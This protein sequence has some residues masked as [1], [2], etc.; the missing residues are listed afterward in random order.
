MPRDMLHTPTTHKVFKTCITWTENMI[1][2]HRVKTNQ[3]K[4]R[5]E[6]V[7]VQFVPTAINFVGRFSIFWIWLGRWEWIDWQ[8]VGVMFK[9]RL[10]GSRDPLLSDPTEKFLA[11]P[12]FRFNGRGHDRAFRCSPTRLILRLMWYQTGSGALSH[13]PWGQRL[14]LWA[15][16]HGALLHHVFQCLI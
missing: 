15:T 10:P 14:Y 13:Q 12:Q 9:W 4:H 6:M 5:G 8:G 1:R 2:Y 11:I 3:A 16:T 7:A